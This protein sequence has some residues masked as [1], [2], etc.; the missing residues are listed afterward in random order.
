M[1]RKLLLVD[2]EAGL[3]R[4]IRLLVQ[5]DGRLQ[6]IGEAGDGHDALDRIAELDPDLV[7]LDLGLPTLDGLEVLARL[8]GRPRPRV[9]VLTGFDDPATHARARELGAAAC[10]VKGRDFDRLL[11]TLAGDASED[12]SPGTA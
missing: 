5:R 3:R 12:G 1:S 6:V 11:D 4:L 7:L 8:R 2:D 10:L 9:V